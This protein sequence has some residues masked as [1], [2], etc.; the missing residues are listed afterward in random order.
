M[1]ELEWLEKIEKTTDT[2][3]LRALYYFHIGDLAKSE[4]FCK[5]VLFYNK[6]N[7]QAMLLLIKINK[8]KKYDT[9]VENLLETIE[10]IDPENEEFLFE[11]GIIT[12]DK[13]L[14]SFKSTLKKMQQYYPESHRYFYMEARF[15]Q[16]EK[17]F[18]KALS[19]INK[20]IYYQANNHQ[21]INLKSEI[22]FKLKKYEFLINLI[23]SNKDKVP[24]DYYR[25]AFLYYMKTRKNLWKV[26]NLDYLEVNILS[27]INQCLNLNA[28]LEIPRRFGEIM[29]ISNTSFRSDVRK[30]FAPYHYERAR[31][32]HNKGYY[33]MARFEYINLIHLLPQEIRYRK[34]Y[35]LLLKDQELHASYL[36]Q[37]EIVKFLE[38]KEDYKLDTKIELLKRK[39]K[40]SLYVKEN[41]KNETRKDFKT[42]ILFIAP[43]EDISLE[44]PLDLAIY[45]NLLLGTFKSV[46]KFDVASCYFKD[47]EKEVLKKRYDFYV[48]Y[49]FQLN[50]DR[51]GVDFNIF[52]VNTRKKLYQHQIFSSG[53]D[54][55]FQLNFSAKKYF[56]SI[57]PLRGSILKTKANGDII[58]SLGILDGLKK[59]QE[60]LIKK[61][62]GTFVSKAK[63]VTLDENIAMIELLDKSKINFVRIGFIIE[64]SKKKK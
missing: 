64:E 52:D 38:K 39:L 10:T 22:L 56:D 55:L 59:D 28:T 26:D 46:I 53:N 20:A 13:D 49:S 54:K 27:I 35:A 62:D 36:N 9:V 16:K 60:V 14:K 8:E 5:K 7:I 11:K 57:I 3:Y 42:R 12:I 40:N 4:I 24:Y 47:F 15:S 25:L 45:H 17:D 48:R 34:K 29:A 32:F 51:V 33:A 1:V 44:N 37:L 31:F 41:I 18:E 50:E 43:Q 19:W 2:F 6:R 61:K 21:Y 23:L 63:V 30:I 58:I